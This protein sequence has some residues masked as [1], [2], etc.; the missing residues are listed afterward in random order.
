MTKNLY[1]RGYKK[2]ENITE[3]IRK[4]FD[5]GNVVRGAFLDLGKSFWYCR[6][7][8]TFSK[9]ESLWIRGVSNDSFKSYLSNRN[10]YVPINGYESGLATVNCGVPLF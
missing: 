1:I 5:D 4:A 9:I 3:N 10:Q 6:P 2:T 8:D 7:P